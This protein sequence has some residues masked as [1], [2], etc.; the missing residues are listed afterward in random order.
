MTKDD[1]CGVIREENKIRRSVKDFYELM[2]YNPAPA[3]GFEVCT[4]VYGGG[5]FNTN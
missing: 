1:V 4:V 2:K 5:L 3:T